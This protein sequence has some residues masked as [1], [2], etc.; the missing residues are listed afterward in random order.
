MAWNQFPAFTIMLKLCSE[1]VDVIN[2][3]SKAYCNKETDTVINPFKFNATI[4]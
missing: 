3:R 1:K 4:I 2:V